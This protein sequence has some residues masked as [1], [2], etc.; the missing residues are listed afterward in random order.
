MHSEILETD[1]CQSFEQVK[2]HLFEEERVGI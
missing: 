1:E 2:S